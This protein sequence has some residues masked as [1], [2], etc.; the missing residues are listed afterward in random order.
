MTAAK[1]TATA[2]TRELT[3]DR[4][5]APLFEEYASTPCETTWSVQTAQHATANQRGCAVKAA[6]SSTIAAAASP[7]AESANSNT[8]QYVYRYTFVV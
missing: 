8:I 2:I 7:A 3:Y 6:G 4:R 1:A 5:P